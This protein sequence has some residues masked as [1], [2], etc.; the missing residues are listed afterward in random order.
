VD[1]VW[2]KDGSR[3]VGSITRWDLDRGLEL[4][5]AS[6][7]LMAIPKKDIGH[8]FQQV[9]PGTEHTLVPA[10]ISHPYAF[11]EVGL[12]H[13]LSTF[14][15]GSADY[16]GAGI[17]YAIGYRFNRKFSLGAGIG[18]ET[19]EINNGRTLF[20]IFAEARGFLKAEK[21]SPYYAMKLGYS[22]AGDNEFFAETATGGLYVAPEVGLRIGSRKVNFFCGI[23]YKYQQAK[24]TTTW[25]P[26]YFFTDKITYKRFEL[27]TGILF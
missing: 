19:N 14:F 17:Q 26:D 12:Y 20:P 16:G 2:L 9:K 22:L 3:L 7:S 27:R 21:V 24:F 4:K 10:R 5:L 18:Y 6:G 23:G 1:V 25:G 8:V 15:H 11:R 13:Q